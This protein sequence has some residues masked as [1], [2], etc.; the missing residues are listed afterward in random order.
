[1]WLAIARLTAGDAAEERRRNPV[2]IFAGQA[3]I[4]DAQ[5]TLKDNFDAG[6]LVRFPNRALFERFEKIE[7]ATENAPTIRFR[8][9]LAQGQQR[10]ISFIDEKHA[11]ADSWELDAGTLDR[12]VH[13]SLF[14]THFT[15]VGMEAMAKRASSACGFSSTITML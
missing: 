13:R 11:D 3:M 12:G 15:S 9:E 5:K 7:L 4:G 10:A 8:G 1:M 6:F 14:P 2:L